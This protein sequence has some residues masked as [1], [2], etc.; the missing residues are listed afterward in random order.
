[1]HLQ[2]KVD[3]VV[4]GREGVIG[5]LSLIHLAS[6]HFCPFLTTSSRSVQ[7]KNA[8]NFHN[9]SQGNLLVTVFD[10]ITIKDQCFV[11]KRKYTVLM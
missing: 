10:G 1:M 11:I 3:S 4:T 2:K 9:I 7:K 6:G 8:E 5:I